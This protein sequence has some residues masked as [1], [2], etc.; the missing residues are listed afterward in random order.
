[1][2]VNAP[3]MSTSSRPVF[4]VRTQSGSFISAISKQPTPAPSTPG[5]DRDDDPFAMNDDDAPSGHDGDIPRTGTQMTLQSGFVTP[6][7]SVNR[8]AE[9]LKDVEKYKSAAVETRK[10][11]DDWQQEAQRNVCLLF[12]SPKTSKINS[13]NSSS[14]PYKQPK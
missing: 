6:V 3:I 1:M 2:R 5:V 12:D 8:V 7:S 4:G 9:L 14:W 13:R 10:Q 11:A